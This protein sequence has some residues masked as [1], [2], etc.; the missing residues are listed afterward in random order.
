MYR[1]N[2]LQPAVGGERKHETTTTEYTSFIDLFTWYLVSVNRL[3]SIKLLDK[4]M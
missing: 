1:H 4:V 3:V 2:S